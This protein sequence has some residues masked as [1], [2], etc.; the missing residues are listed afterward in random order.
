MLLKK[1]LGIQWKWNEMKGKER[2]RECFSVMFLLISSSSL[3]CMFQY[4][5][6]QNQRQPNGQTRKLVQE[7]DLNKDNS[8]LFF[9]TRVSLIHRTVGRTRKDFPRFS[10]IKL[11][12]WLQEIQTV[13]SKRSRWRR[14]GDR[15]RT[16]LYNASNVNLHVYLHVGLLLF[17]K[18]P[19]FYPFPSPNIP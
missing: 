13:S 2:K 15:S 9:A 17:G 11:F 3:L 6:T 18:R 16:T 8:K 14:Y 4:K 7:F 19:I 1:L 5:P 12:D 10:K